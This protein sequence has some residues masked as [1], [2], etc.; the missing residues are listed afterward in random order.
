[1]YEANA[2][3]NAGSKPRVSHPASFI[4]GTGR[5][6]SSRL[7]HSKLLVPAGSVLLA[8]LI[9]AVTMVVLPGRT[10]AEEKR[11]VDSRLRVPTAE[12]SST[13]IEGLSDDELEPLIDLQQ[14]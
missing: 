10:V 9:F 3:V 8:A 12:V 13:V 4:D 5:V 1:M 7:A 11:A 14:E 6:E 2:V